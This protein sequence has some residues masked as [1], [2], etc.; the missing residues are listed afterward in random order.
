MEVLVTGAEGFIGRNLC[1]ELSNRG[2]GVLKF[3]KNDSEQDLNAAIKKADFIFHLAGINRPLSPHEFIDGN[4]DFTKKLLDLVKAS[5]RKVPILFSSS[6]QALSDNDYGKSKKMAEDLLFDFEKETGIP[7]FIFQLTN[8]FGKW[9]RPNYNSVIATFCFNITHNLDIVINNPDT[10]VSFVYIDDVVASFISVLSITSRRL[11]EG[12]NGVG[13]IYKVKL[14]DL[15]KRLYFFKES[16]Q[17][18]SLPNL[19]DDFEKKLY[20]TYLSY[21]EP[22]N[23][24]Y[25]LET[26]EDQ[27]GSFTEIFK[28]SFHGQVSLNITKPGETKG[29]HWH[30]TKIEKFLVVSG[31]GLIKFRKVD[32]TKVLEYKV[33]GT[34]LQMVDIP[35][36]YTH[37]ITNTGISD[38]IVLIWAS[39]PFDPKKPDTYRLEVML[40]NKH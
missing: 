26:N 24:S 31:E 4:V 40:P 23:F 37:S 34:T 36:G 29:N 22:N 27:R 28:T 10:E 1:L 13:P 35:C 25:L 11:S 9:A 14:G 33:T 7:I 8:V 6:I 19:S 12:P 39:E 16:R 38:L 21:L 3:D 30:Q 5:G 2:Y 15:V 20:A 18:L 17:L 32:E